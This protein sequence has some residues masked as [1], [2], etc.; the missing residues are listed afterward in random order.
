MD[1]L[2]K[3]VLTQAVVLSAKDMSEK[4]I[5]KGKIA[6]YYNEYK[7]TQSNSKYMSINIAT[8]MCTCIYMHIIAYTHINVYINNTLEGI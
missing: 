5:L 3:I 4:I 2:Q 7:N 6:N 1:F 8:Y